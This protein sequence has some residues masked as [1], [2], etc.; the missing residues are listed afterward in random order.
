MHICVYTDYW[1]PLRMSQL[2]VWIQGHVATCGMFW[3]ELL[4]REGA[5]YSHHIGII[6]YDCSNAYLWDLY[7][8][9]LNV[10]VVT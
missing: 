10:F 2:Q 8:V 1:F 7:I 9:W 5:S 6:L 3:L 4:E